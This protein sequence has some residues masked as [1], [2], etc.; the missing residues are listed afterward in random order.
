ML[1]KQIEKATTEG[2]VIG[3][4]DMNL[5]LN[6]WESPGYYLKK[7]AECYQTCLAENALELLEFGDTWTRAHKNGSV[8]SSAIDH[9]FTNDSKL[10]KIE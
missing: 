10:I 3:I 6:H 2:K 8:R 5:D 1:C 4:G 7:V 9:A